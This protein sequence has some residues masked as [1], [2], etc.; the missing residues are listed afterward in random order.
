MSVPAVKAGSRQVKVCFV[1]N[2]VSML[3]VLTES[4]GA[5]GSVTV[6]EVQPY[7]WIA[8]LVPGRMLS[9]LLATV[10]QEKWLQ[11]TRPGL[12]KECD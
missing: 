10:K 12:Y 2:Q 8:K 5:T 7:L 4:A 9:I 3:P 1:G 11:R 6:V